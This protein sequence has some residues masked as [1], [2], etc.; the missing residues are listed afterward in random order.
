MPC[1]RSRPEVSPVRQ[2]L[3]QAADQLLHRRFRPARSR[4]RLRRRSRES[5][6]PRKDR[7]APD[8]MWRYRELLP[9]DGEPTVGCSRRHAAG[10]GRSAGRGAWAWRSV[11][12][13]NDAVNFPTLS[14]KD[15]VVSVALSKAARVRLPH[16]RLRLDRQPG[17]QRRR[18]RRRRRA[19]KLHLRPRG[20]GTSQDPRHQRLRRQ[21]HRRE[22]HLRRGQSPVYPGGLQVRLGLRQHQPAALLRRGLED[23][24]LRD[25]R[26]ARL[27]HPAARRLPRWPAAA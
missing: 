10:Q 4:L 17:Q 18:Q 9:L 5:L 1:F 16:G 26:A 12:L 20:S 19:G 25:R 13:K 22:R 2:D 15:R 7:D 14:F 8:N 27:A 3:S 11:W 24:R 21:G 23:D 6:S